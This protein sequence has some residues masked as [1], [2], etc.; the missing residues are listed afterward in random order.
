MRNQVP[1]SFGPPASS[2]AG[3]PDTEQWEYKIVVKDAKD[4][5]TPAYMESLNRL[6]IEGWELV[7][8]TPGNAMIK[9]FCYY[10]K[11]RLPIR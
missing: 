3:A 9:H 6:G 10:L 5:G 11:R 4:M 1:G 8:V 7:S 2:Y